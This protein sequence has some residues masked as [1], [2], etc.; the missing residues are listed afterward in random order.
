MPPLVLSFPKYL[1]MSV[2]SNQW[3]VQNRICVGVVC[4]VLG[5]GMSLTSASF[6]AA[7][8]TVKTVKIDIFGI[9]ARGSHL[10][11]FLANGSDAVCE[12]ESETVRGN[13]AAHD[14]CHL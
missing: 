14:S 2:Y 5:N 11:Q 7:L 10:L 1:L 6:A 4:A 3:A 13:I 8:D 12:L 9:E